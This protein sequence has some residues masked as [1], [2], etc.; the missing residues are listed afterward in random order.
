MGRLR[1]RRGF[2]VTELMMAIILLAVAVLSTATIISG[3]TSTQTLSAYRGEMAMLA[4][5][6]LES[7][8]I[9]LDASDATMIAALQEGGSVTSNVS[10]YTDLVTG[11]STTQFRR[12]WYIE[13]APALTS[14]VTMRIVPVTPTSRMP[15]QVELVTYMLI[16]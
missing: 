9:G 15:A 10:G 8:R 11:P 1:P 6:K 2:T 12:R 14:K 3:T 16:P 13:T 7:F 4:A 5:S